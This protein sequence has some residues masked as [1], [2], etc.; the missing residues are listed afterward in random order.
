[1]ARNA[2]NRD[3]G[4]LI[5]LAL[6]RWGRTGPRRLGWV[7]RR[8]WHL[9]FAECR[10]RWRVR[11]IDG[12]IPWTVAISP[13]M[14]CNYSCE[15]CYSRGRPTEDELTAGELDAL[16][17]EAEGLGVLSV[18]VT[19]GEPLLRDGLVDILA[20][21]QRLLFVLITNGS[22]VTAA[23]A[24]RIAA[25]GNIIPLVSI[26]G[27]PSDTDERRCPGAHS[28]GL[29]ALA[30]FRD[31]GLCFGFAAMNTSTN[32][33]HL[34]TEEFID[35]MA[36]R[37]CALGFMTEY[38]P[39]DT[40]PRSDWFLSEN[41]RDTF[42]RRVLDLRKRKR[43]VLIQFPHDEYGEDNRC[44][45][46]G[47][48]SLHIGSRGEVEPC[49]FVPIACDNVRDGGLLA[50]CESPFMR[51]IRGRPNLL[52]RGR[53]ACSLFEHREELDALAREHGARIDER[54][55]AE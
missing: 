3:I 10:R 49:P 35:R 9:L 22:L 31:A 29:D 11:G 53:F 25:S 15:G 8:A 34:A 39:C 16:F 19:G 51:A 54:S 24:K 55:A 30:R 48:A 27:F 7:I 20:S 52:K 12:S 23:V 42:R 21:H 38:V 2:T 47:Q 18:V 50:A 32:T 37:G 41:S 5:G 1:L 26:E 13:T 33:D 17:G 4:D 40:T 28:A 6:W 46:A 45:A 14:R 36:D 44:S 43:L